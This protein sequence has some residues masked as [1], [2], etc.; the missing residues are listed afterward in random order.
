MEYKEVEYKNQRIA[1]MAGSF[2]F[3]ALI[4]TLFRTIIFPYIFAPISIILAILSKGKMKKNTVIARLAI[5]ISILSILLNTAIAGYSYYTVTHDPK[6]REQLNEIFEEFYGY[7][8]DEYLQNLSITLPFTQTDNTEGTI[9]SLKN[10]NT[11]DTSSSSQ[12]R[13]TED[14]QPDSMEVTQ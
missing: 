5:L 1:G 14:T 11:D 4:S 13:N 3:V 2:A 7:S 10:D 12:N 6:Y 8:F 9:P